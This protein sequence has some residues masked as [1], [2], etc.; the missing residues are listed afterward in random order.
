MA[1]AEK[2]L[3]GYITNENKTKMTNPWIK[4][5]ELL[6]D[7]LRHDNNGQFRG[8]VLSKCSESRG[9]LG[10]F[11]VSGIFEPSVTDTVPKNDDT[12]GELIVQFLVLL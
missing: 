5:H 9:E 6:V 10:H 12:I 4:H 7:S 2:K 1:R 11:V 8:V 3:V